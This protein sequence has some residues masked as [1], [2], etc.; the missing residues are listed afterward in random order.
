MQSNN[1]TKHTTIH[2]RNLCTI[3]IP[4]FQD[5]KCHHFINILTYMHLIKRY[6]HASKF[7]IFLEGSLFS[8]VKL[9]FPRVW[10][11]CMLLFTSIYLQDPLNSESIYM[12]TIKLSSYMYA[13]RENLNHW[14]KNMPCV[15]PLYVSQQY[16]VNTGIMNIKDR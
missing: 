7:L 16:M 6:G 10:E 11:N 9:Q 12:Q 14:I 3:I 15:D 4:S 5:W 1:C 2:K 8:M 13:R